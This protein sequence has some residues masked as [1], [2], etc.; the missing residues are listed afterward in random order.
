MEGDLPVHKEAY[1]RGR[2]GAFTR[3]YSDRTRF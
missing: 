3:A 2:E 1:E